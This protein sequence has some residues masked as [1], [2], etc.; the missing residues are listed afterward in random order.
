MTPA[1]A[2][3]AACPCG[4]QT[5]TGARSRPLRYAQCCGR[6]HAGALHLAAPD[7]PS[8]MR[9]R[10]S[11]FVL[12]LPDYLLATWHPNTRPATLAP[13]EPGLRWLGLELRAQAVQSANHA[14]VEFIARSKLGGRAQRLHEISRFVREADSRW[15]Y[16]DGQFPT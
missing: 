3:L 2:D 7:A 16:L 13:N 11:A 8:L 9:S 10:Y 5:G 15:Y 14:T 6:W 12:W 1:P 4:A